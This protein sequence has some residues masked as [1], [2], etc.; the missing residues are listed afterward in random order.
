MIDFRV[1][2]IFAHRKTNCTLAK[3][4]NILL[5]FSLGDIRDQFVEHY[6]STLILSCCSVVLEDCRCD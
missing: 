6:M 1:L 4:R 3:Y 5:G 2:T